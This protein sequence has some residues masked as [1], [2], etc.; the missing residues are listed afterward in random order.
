VTCGFGHVRLEWTPT[1]ETTVYAGVKIL[2][3]VIFS[4]L[5]AFD[6]VRAPQGINEVGEQNENRAE[7]D[8]VHSLN[9][10][11]NR[12]PIQNSLLSRNA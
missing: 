9:N 12:G 3:G 5:K 6:G 7:K 2:H 1:P 8:Q 4:E 11:E 10:G